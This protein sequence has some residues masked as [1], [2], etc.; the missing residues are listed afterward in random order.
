[1]PDTAGHLALFASVCVCV[2]V[3]VC[4][5][6]SIFEFSP[7]AGHIWHTSQWVGSADSVLLPFQV[8][9]KLKRAAARDHC[10]ESCLLRPWSWVLG[11][12]SSVQR[13]G[14][15]VLRPSSRHAQ[16]SLHTISAISFVSHSFPR[17]SHLSAL[18]LW[19]PP[20]CTIPYCSA[21]LGPSH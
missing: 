15:R 3:C 11:P 10:S 19:L 5:F 18:L 7:G 21:N 2:H 14:S 6:S 20:F 1:M 9:S 12:A 8:L 16:L 13:C 17:F 4:V